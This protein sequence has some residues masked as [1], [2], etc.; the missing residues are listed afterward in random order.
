VSYSTESGRQ[1]ILDEAAAAVEE[2]GTALAVLADAYDHLDEHAADRVEESVFRPLQAAYGQ[3]RRTHAEFAARYNLPARTFRPGNA[4]L[5]ADVR[6]LL[7]RIADATQAAE[8]GLAALQDSLLPVEV[9]DAELRAGLSRTRTLIASVPATCDDI[10]R[11]I[12]R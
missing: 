8:D 4:G 12:G 3:L 11:T 6:V 2:L 1:Q 7:E 5:P 9:G 10:V